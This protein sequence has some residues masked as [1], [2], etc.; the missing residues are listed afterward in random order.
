[1]LRPVPNLPTGDDLSDDPEI[2][3]ATITH[4]HVE[5]VGSVSKLAFN[6]KSGDL[7]VLITITAESEVS[8]R[9]LDAL[10]RRLLTIRLTPTTR[11]NSNTASSATMDPVKARL[12]E[13]R[14][15]RASASW[16]TD[17]D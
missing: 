5:F 11:S 1:M 3:V 6:P 16:L 17:D 4:T 14:F 7:Q 10:R 8:N 13:E 9:D 12:I 2:P 15:N